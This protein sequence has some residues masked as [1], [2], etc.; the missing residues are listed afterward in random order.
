MRT[1]LVL[2]GAASLAEDVSRYDGPVDGVVACNDAGY[3][4]A[5]ELDAWVS[6]HPEYLMSKDWYDER[7]RRGYPAPKRCLTHHEG[8]NNL[9]KR[10]PGGLPV[11][12]RSTSFG[13]T[14]HCV[15]G[16]SGLLAAK[17]ALVDLGF[18]HAVLCGIPLDTAPH[19]WDP[20]KERW[21]PGPLFR[22]A[23]L[24]IPENYRNRMRSMSG[25]TRIL[26][27]SPEPS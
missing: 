22:Q 20:K 19:F 13:F 9:S 5:G 2:G 16:S 25:W 14:D 17:V 21:S 27:G 12:I 4:W 7:Q 10:A 11:E 6:L 15:S 23:W 3:W 24:G 1:A 18:D 8:L 26:L